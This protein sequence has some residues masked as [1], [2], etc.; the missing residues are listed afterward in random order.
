MN[1]RVRSV[2]WPSDMLLSGAVD[3]VTIMVVRIT[4]GGEAEK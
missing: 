4:I 1:L 2:T 3:R